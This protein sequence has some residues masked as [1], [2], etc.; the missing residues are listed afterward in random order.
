MSEA[1]SEIWEW[2]WPGYLIGLAIFLALMLLLTWWLLGRGQK[3]V[4]DLQ[5]EFDKMEEERGDDPR[6]D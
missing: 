2:W 4:D 5:A 1:I 3:A 6:A